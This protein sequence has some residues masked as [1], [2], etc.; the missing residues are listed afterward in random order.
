[1]IE[2]RTKKAGA[3][4]ISARLKSDKLELINGTSLEVAGNATVTGNTT[5]TGNLTVN[6][7]TTTLSTATLDV[8]DKNIT[9]NKGSGDTSASADGAGITIQDAVD[10]S[11]DATILW[12][13][14]KII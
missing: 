6:G 8:E 1:M 9:L 4:N 13:A 5:I 10:A 14:S 3:N 7:T 11:N 12:D 2:F